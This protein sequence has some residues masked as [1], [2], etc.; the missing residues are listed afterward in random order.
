MSIKVQWLGHASFKIAG[1][2]VIYIDPWKLE[3]VRH[4]ADIVLV[5]HSHH[6]H[7]C[8]EDIKKVTTDK[9][10]LL[11]SGDVIQK[12]NSG[13]V[14][15]PGESV[16]YGDIR[17]S[18]IASY[19]T[20]KQFH[21]NDNQWLGFLIN[22]DGKTIYYAGDTDLTDEMRVLTDIDLALIP[23]G[24]TYT[25]DAQQAAQAV[26][27]FSPSQALPYHWGDIVGTLEDAKAFT[28]SAKCNTVI[29]QKGESVTLP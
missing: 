16:E 18:A 4:D 13:Q 7:Y 8:M 1:E 12:H 11:A 23:V 22:M 28:N 15:R 3:H 6:D 9:T 10:Q 20:N 14:L 29:L 24:G 2:L 21:P 27:I 19:N 17:I 25:M 5:S 26:N